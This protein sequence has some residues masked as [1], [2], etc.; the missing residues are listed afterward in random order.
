MRSST[1]TDNPAGA[2]GNRSSLPLA[3][4]LSQV[5]VAFTIEFDN[6]TERQMQ[7]GTTRHGSKGA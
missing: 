5:L 7:H 1:K 2:G 4:L 6:E 3:T